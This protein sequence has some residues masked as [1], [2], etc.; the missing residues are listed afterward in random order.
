MLVKD[1]GGWV[2]VPCEPT[3]KGK[4][5]SPLLM[6]TLSNFPTVH[7]NNSR[8]ITLVLHWVLLVLKPETEPVF[9]HLLPQK[10]NRKIHVCLMRPS[11]RWESQKKKVDGKATESN[12]HH[13]NKSHFHYTDFSFRK[14]HRCE[15][16]CYFYLFNC[17]VP[18]KLRK[19]LLVFWC[20]Y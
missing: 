19:P 7:Q 13:K 11:S 1:R 3:L 14:W 15:S 2:Y 4:A 5:Y 12:P 8:N 10:Q 9:K 16:L 17:Q 20:V 6:P 18:I